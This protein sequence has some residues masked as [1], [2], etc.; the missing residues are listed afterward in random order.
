MSVARLTTSNFRNLSAAAIDFHP[1]FNFFIGD[2]GSGKSSLLEAIFFLAHGKSFRTSKAEHIAR[3]DTVNFVVSIKDVNDLQLGLSKDLQT[4]VTLIKIN[5]ERHARLSDLA[6]NIA[7]QIVTPE[8]F[9]LFFGGPKERR[10]FVELGMFH[11]K[12][13]STKQWREFNR[14]LKQRNAC[15]RQNL[16]KETFAYWTKLFCQLSE[17]IA[18]VRAQYIKGLISELPFWLD[19]LLPN[20]ADKV[21]VQYLQGWPQK[22]SLIDALN[23][24]QEREQAFGYSIYG[25]HKFDV[26]FLIAKQALESQLSRGQQKLFLLALT[27]AQAKL[28]ARV[29]RVKPI[30]LIDDIGAELDVN[31]RNSLS[32]A[33]SILDCQVVITAIEE[34]VLQPFISDT[35]VTDKESSNKTK[36]HMFHVKQG[37]I[38]PVNN[39][40]KIE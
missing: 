15:L 16:N 19:I 31:S 13:D 18:E 25:A 7:V 21:T 22:K 8:S 35:F 27:F 26:K 36:Y 38:L 3:Y 24:S 34:G 14:V 23:D 10:R 1:K 5:G 17:D 11:V 33:L 40:V 12:H 2:N 32:R 4:G 30:L 6:K 9:K 29:N 37:G 20:I 39:S 28:I